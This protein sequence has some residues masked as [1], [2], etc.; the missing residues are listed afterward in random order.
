MFEN[1]QEK[2]ESAFKTLKGQGQITELN[3]AATMKEIRRALVDADVNY[4][5]AK[6]FTDKV[7][8]EALGQKVLIAVQPGQLLVKIMSDELTKLMGS[9]VSDITISGNPAVILISGLQGSGKTTFSSKLAWYLKNNRK[10]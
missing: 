4:K 2:L 6:E 5:I 3:V 9:T 7:R 1:L 8:D 10:K